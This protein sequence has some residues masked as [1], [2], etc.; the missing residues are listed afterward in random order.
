MAACGRR[1][2]RRFGSLAASCLLVTLMV[3]LSGAAAAEPGTLP[4][5]PGAAGFG[6]HTTAGSGRHLDKPQTRVIKVTNLNPSGPGS[7]RAAVEAEG[8]RVVVFE[9]AGNIDFSPLGGLSIRE[10][11]ITIA[12]QTAPSPGITLKACQLSIRTHDVLMQ[13]LRVRVGDLTDPTQPLQNPAGWSQWSERD[14]MK[15]DGERIVI[16]HCSF[17]WATDE[18]VQTQAS[19]LTFRHNLFAECLDSYKHHKGG[20]SKALLILD[21]G[22]RDPN[23]RNS[24]YVDMVGNLFAYNA[25]RCPQAVGGAKIVF[26]NNLVYDMMLKP[27]AGVTLISTPFQETGNRGGPIIAS[28]VGNYF[29]KVPGPI[30]VIARSPEH[31]GE[32]Y[33]GEQTVAYTPAER[34]AM[35]DLVKVP[36]DDDQLPDYRAGAPDLSGRDEHELIREQIRDPWTASHMFIFRHWMGERIDPLHA[37]RDEPT[38]EV[39][40][41]QIQ[42]S[43]EVRAWVLKHAGA[44]PADRDP[45]D[46]RVIRQVRERSGRIIQSQDDVGGWPELQENYRSLTVPDNPNGDDDGDGYTNLEEWLH[47]FAAEV[48]GKPRGQRPRPAGVRHSA[49]LGWAAGQDVT[50]SFATLLASGKLKAGTELVLD[51]TYRI[52]GSHELPDR[53]T[54]SAVK[55]AG[56]D[57]TDA[58]RPP[59]SRPLLELGDRNTL[60][61][62]TI[63]YLETPPLGPTG[64]KH[65]VNFTRRVGIQARGKSDLLIEHC[66]LVGSIG[67]HIK[68]ND[69]TKPRIVGTHIAGG[70]WSV[71]LH[72][73]QEMVFRRCLIEKCQGDAIKVGGNG[74][75]MRKAL[76]EHCVFQDNLRDGIDST[77]GI[78]DSIVRQCTFRRMGVSG[79]DLKSGYDLDKG[80]LSESDLVPEN[81]GIL[82]EQCLFHDMPNAIVLT[83]IDGGR[84]RGK[85]LLNA[86]NIR[87]Y[88]VHDINIH[89]CVFGYVEKPLKKSHDGG[90]GVNYPSKQGEHMRMVH[91]KDAYDIRYKDARLFGERIIPVAINSIGGTRFLSKEAAGALDRTIDGTVIELSAPPVK[92]GVTEVPFEVGPQMLEEG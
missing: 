16:D 48:E 57:V 56:F 82:I 49:D 80:R 78:N 47:G 71:Y 83:T 63:T 66:R 29:D 22:S 55:G 35:E 2:P 7:L 43:S 75:P 25:D 18:L 46:M 65:E 10:P 32:I 9:V 40:G 84:R 54:L 42:P 23:R 89:D 51:H 4:I 58:A 41:L 19:Q 59:G 61:N 45:V 12:G 62:L 17:S 68:M 14:C 53:F 36:L 88:A 92:S 31:G 87:K 86:T 6:I 72:G 67:H 81:V 44:R 30:K 73:N 85:E 69:C 38:I 37:R 77:G 90:Y 70:H 34:R 21:Q 60:R 39:P 79:M 5:I 91:L 15:I 52:S 74:N 64:E 8:P 1:Y 24:R 50:E 3:L 76:L 33:L 27:A 11:Y 28:V 20:H 13:H 26:A